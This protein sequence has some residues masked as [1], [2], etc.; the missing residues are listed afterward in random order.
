MRRRDLLTVVGGGIALR[1]LVGLA[2]PAKLTR[3]GWLTAQEAAG[4]AAFLAA[5]RSGLAD[6]GYV[7]G[8]NLVIESRFGDNDLDR[9]PDL[10]AELLRLPVE[11]IVAQGP[12]VRVLGKLKLPIPVIYAYSGDPVV[13]GL[14]ESL[15]RPSGNM[16]GITLMMADL[17]GKR[18]E[19]LRELVP[20]LHRVA[21][22]ARPEH[23]GEQL[24]RAYSEDSGRRLGLSI[25][26]FQTSDQSG[27]DAA[28]AR[29]TADP[30]QA[31]SVF[32]DGF[33]VRHRHRIIDFATS[34]KVPLTSG[35]RIFAASGA[36]CTYGPTLA[37]SYQRLAYFVDRVLRG[38]KPADLPIE[39]PT[40]YELVINLK[41]AKALGLA[42]PQSLLARADEVIE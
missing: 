12:A 7:E 19:V 30:P 15:A 28:F 10:A 14:A 41:T 22:L 1:P 20:D 9:I 27:L 3:I 5:L 39:Q 38:A 35:W 37:E 8:R 11:L 32:P 16:T 2:Q 13:A 17:S 24:E 40:K 6:R 36:I 34:A 42:V 26:Y 33:M 23:P 21:I 25:A 18:L 4:V 29:M 31:I